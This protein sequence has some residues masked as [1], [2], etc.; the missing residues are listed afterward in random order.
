[1]NHRQ[2]DA[3]GYPNDV[4]KGTPKEIEDA[5]VRREFG[6]VVTRLQIS[7]MHLFLQVCTCVL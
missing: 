6:F 7:A 1:M 5:S 4:L 2:C 3:Y